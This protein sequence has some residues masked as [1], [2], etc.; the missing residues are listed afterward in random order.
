MEG[1]EGTLVRRSDSLRF[2]L[3]VQLIHQHAALQVDAADLEPVR[4]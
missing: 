2:V 1:V 3:T 4:D